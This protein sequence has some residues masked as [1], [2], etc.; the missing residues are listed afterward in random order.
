MADINA[1]KRG[2]IRTIHNYFREGKRRVSEAEEAIG[3]VADVEA[4]RRLAEAI[5]RIRDQPLRADTR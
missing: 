5:D 4:A 2:V 3:R 1:G